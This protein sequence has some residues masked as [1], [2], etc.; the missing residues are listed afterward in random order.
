MFLVYLL[1]MIIV[2]FHKG[3]SVCQGKGI[4][5]PIE[6]GQNL[7]SWGDPGFSF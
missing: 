3:A 4:A 7:S 2:F 1:K 6:T 5:V